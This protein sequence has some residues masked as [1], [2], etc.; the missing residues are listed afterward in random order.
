MKERFMQNNIEVLFNAA[1]DKLTTTSDIEAEVL[2]FYSTLLGTAALWAIDD[3]KAPIQEI[4]AALWAID[5]DKAPGVLLPE[6]NCT[7][8]TLI[9]KIPNLSLVKDFRLIA[10]CTKLYKII[11]KILT[12]RMQNMIGIVVDLAQAWFM[13]GRNISDNILLAIELIKSYNTKH[14]SPRCMLKVD[15][16]KAYDSIE[17]SFLEAVLNDIGFPSPFVKWI[18]ACVTSVSFSILINNGSSCKPFTARKGLRQGDPM[19]LFLFALGMEYLSRCL[20]N[21]KADPRFN[22]HPRCKKLNITHVMFADDLLMFS[23]ANQTSLQLVFDAFSKFSQAS[24][25]EANLDKCHLYIGG[26]EETQRAILQSVVH[27]PLGCFPFKYLGVPLT[28]RKLFYNECKP[29]IEKTMARVRAWCLRRFKASVVCR[30]F[31]WTGQDSYS[32]KAPIARDSL[33]LPISCGALNI[34]N[35]ALWNKAAVAKHLWAVCQ[36]QDRLWIKWLHEYYIKQQ[37]IL[38]MVIPN[39]LSWSMKKVLESREIFQD[40][41]ATHM[42]QLNDFSIKKLYLLMQGEHDQVNWKRIVCNNKASPKA[43]F[44]TW[45]ILHGRLATKDRLFSWGITDNDFCPLCTAASE[46]ISHLFFDCPFSRDIW[47]AC[48]Q[49]LK[50]VVTLRNL[51]DEIH[52]V[53]LKSKR[54][55]AK[56]QLYCMMF[57]EAMYQ[58]WLQRNAKVYGGLMLDTVTNFRQICFRV[59]SR[60]NDCTRQLLLW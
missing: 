1:G 58:I 36:K 19:S 31:L 14:I 56:A 21:L 59:A 39:R 23:K 34:K 25:L 60:C 54:R 18:M 13:P 49:H 44:V 35:L 57:A 11:A 29:L 2:N 24:G 37:H 9:P 52:V 10:Y 16:K 7:L 30:V 42:L 15:L 22:F 3:D 28:T 4:E 40:L 32:G 12:N 51:S 26:V 47:N 46:S 8:V 6:I 17:W 27:M 33:C 50:V 5:D 43:L 48:Q 55:G 41:Q 38:S 45:L 20:G 53:A